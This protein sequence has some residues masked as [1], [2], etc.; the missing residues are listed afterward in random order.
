LRSDGS[1]INHWRHAL[2]AD[3]AGGDWLMSKQFIRG[4]SAGALKG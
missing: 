1:S 3:G 2:G 4:L